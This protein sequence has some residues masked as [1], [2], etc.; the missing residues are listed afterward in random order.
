M[1]LRLEVP[2]LDDTGLGVQNKQ[3]EE[4][5]DQKWIPNLKSDKLL[6]FAMIP[7]VDSSL[8][9]TAEAIFPLDLAWHGSGLSKQV[10]LPVPPLELVAVARSR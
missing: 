4:L 5:R 6:C 1:V 2:Y 3:T 7:S 8:T 10:L 9:S